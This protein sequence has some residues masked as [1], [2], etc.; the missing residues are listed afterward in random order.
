MSYKI[1]EGDYARHINPIINGGLRMYVEDID[2]NHIQAKCSHFV[3]IEAVLEA[4]WFNI[5]D[6]ILVERGDGRFID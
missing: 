5:D 4:D 1:K 3:G 6:L 2:K